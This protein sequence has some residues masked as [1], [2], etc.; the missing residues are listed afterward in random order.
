METNDV[1]VHVTLDTF[2]G[3]QNIIE[4]LKISIA[5]AKMRKETLGHI[6]LSGSKGSGKSALAYAVADE[7]N[8]NISISSFNEIRT[9][10]DL[11]AV[12]TSL[13][14]GDVLIVENFD[15][16]TPECA[17]LFYSAMK[18]FCMNVVVGKG[19]S[20]RNIRLDLPSFTLIAIM[21]IKRSVIPKLMDCFFLNIALMGYSTDELIQLAKRWSLLNNTDITDEAAKIIALYADGSNRRLTNVLKRARDFATIINNGTINLDVADKT[22]NAMLSSDFV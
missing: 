3:Q 19:P 6:L 15:A 10:S 7:L 8:V 17:E 5:A 1:N 2:I 22:I 9:P 14:E 20:A 13:N 11:A 12:L 4:N 21:D 18:M 16:I